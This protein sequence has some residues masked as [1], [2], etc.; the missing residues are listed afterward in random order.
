MFTNIAKVS[1][2]AALKLYNKDFVPGRTDWT[3]DRTEGKSTNTATARLFFV[4]TKG[5]IKLHVVTLLSSP[6]GKVLVDPMRKKGGFVILRP[7]ADY[8]R[9]G[10]FMG[11]R[12]DVKVK[13][14]PP[15][16]RDTVGNIEPLYCVSF[17]KRASATLG[18]NI[19][20]PMQLL[21]V[22]WDERE[23]LGD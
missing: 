20:T 1:Q 5:L 23:I 11:A 14:R 22:L 15:Y 18:D 16:A 13:V 12:Y 3:V 19:I 4:P 21:R 10:L 9:L 7:N 8:E 17:A 6:R 2:Y